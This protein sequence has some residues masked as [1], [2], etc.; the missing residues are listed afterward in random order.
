MTPAGSGLM[1]AKCSITPF[2]DCPQKCPILI[3]LSLKGVQFSG[4]FLSRC[5]TDVDCRAL[6]FTR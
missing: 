4:G 5:L 3:V 1:K 6:T 2:C